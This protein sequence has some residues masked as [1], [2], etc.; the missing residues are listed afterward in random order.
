[1]NKNKTLAVTRVLA[2]ILQHGVKN[3]INLNSFIM[4]KTGEGKK[5]VYVAPHKRNGKKVKPHYRSTPN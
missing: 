4:A 1:M 5:K 2:E 3:S